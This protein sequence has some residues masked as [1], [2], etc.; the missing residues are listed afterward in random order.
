MQQLVQPIPIL[1]A[2]ST[3]KD[4]QDI[5]KNMGDLE[6]SG[7]CLSENRKVG[8]RGTQELLHRLLL[9]VFAPPAPELAAA[10]PEVLA[11]IPEA[12]LPLEHLLH[13]Y[14]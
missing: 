10:P 14:A 6:C 9:R 11:R 3:I 4:T 12:L 2:S 5:C 1:N 7:A 13:A 8:D